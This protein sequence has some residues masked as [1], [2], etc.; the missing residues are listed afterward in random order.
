MSQVTRRS[1][2]RSLSA[3]P[4]AGIA[5]ALPS[6]ARAAEFSYKYGNNLPVTHPLNIRAQE[7]ADRILKET[8]G[9]VEIKIFP[10][11]QLGGD[12]DMLAQVRS[13][14]IEFFTPS[15]LVIATL[16]PVAAINAVGFAFSDYNQVWNAM[17]GKLGAHVR[18]AIGKMRLYAFDKMW[19]NGFRQTTSSKAAVT[20][21]KDLD[22][23][24]IRVP[25]SPLSISMFKGLG[26]APASLQFSEVYSSLQTK[27]VDAQENP[28]PIIQVAKLYEVQKFCSLTNHI[29]DGYWFIANGK[30]WDRLPADLKT[31]VAAA[32][33]ESGM[34][35]R[36]DIKKL[37]DS[38]V[39][40][41]EAKGLSINRPTS[42]SFRAKLRESGFYSEWKGRFGNEAWGLL[43]Q[44][45][46]KL[47]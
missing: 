30:A 35:Q 15:A 11:N 31:I 19:D 20:S 2:L 18:A 27:I 8:K 44:S 13:G 16:V 37:N 29:W 34:K 12:T 14:G 21:A 39:S 3:V 28:L 41:L 43:E 10:N 1:V 6:M 42:E 4:A 9:R 33:N 26:A 32:I 38:V 40:D 23:L 22:G 7:A 45:V 36:E 24:K 17:D 5:A 25:V 46:G 47:A